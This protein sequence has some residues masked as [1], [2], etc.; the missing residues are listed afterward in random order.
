M[1]DESHA[2]SIRLDGDVRLASEAGV[3]TRR[4][5]VAARHSEV[6]AVRDGRSRDLVQRSPAT[7]ATGQAGP[8][9][10]VGERGVR[11]P[12]PTRPAPA[13]GRTTTARPP[14]RAP[15]AATRPDTGP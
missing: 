15:A 11:D 6:G 5:A 9:Q 8:A 10:R 7:G 13:A 3:R 12:R 1:R 2:T 14:T 4:E